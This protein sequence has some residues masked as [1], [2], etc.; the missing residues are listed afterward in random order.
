MAC[1]TLPF[2]SLPSLPPCNVAGIGPLA[3]GNFDAALV[4]VFAR[5][6]TFFR[7]VFAEKISVKGYIQNQ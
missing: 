6:R 1:V 4:G 2:F 3:A 7:V 5:E